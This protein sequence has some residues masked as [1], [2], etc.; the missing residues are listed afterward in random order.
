MLPSRSSEAS[1]TVDDARQGLQERFEIDERAGRLCSGLQLRR[2]TKLDVI[3]LQAEAEK[4]D[5][6]FARP[7][8]IGVEP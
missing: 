5:A 8:R 4:L 1:D 2:L 7:D 6:E 3:E